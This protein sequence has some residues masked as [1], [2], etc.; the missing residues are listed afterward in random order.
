[1]GCTPAPACKALLWQAELLWPN[2]STASDGIC[3]SPK[4]T[5]QN[6]TSDHEIGNAADLTHDP[7][8]GCDAHA[9][10]ERLKASGD[11]R[12]K[13]VISDGRIWNPA[14]SPNWRAYTG[15][16]P[17]TKHIHVSIHAHLRDDVSAWALT[18][19]EP[20]DDMPWTDTDSQNL[21]AVKALLES[22]NHQIAAPADKGG[23]VARITA[24]V[25]AIKT[26]VAG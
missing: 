16:N 17:H 22:I 8:N 12:I 25:E 20:E 6:P 1:M 10:A 24:A 13:Y 9:I 7:V 18:P 4:H 5:Q 2:R 23:R 15:S 19:P 11:P 21:A 3:A 14:K 26:K